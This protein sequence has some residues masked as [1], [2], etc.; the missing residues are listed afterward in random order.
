[1]FRTLLLV[2]LTLLPAARAATPNL[3][4][5]DTDFGT[6]DS[7]VRR[8]IV[9]Q[10]GDI[11]SC[12][13]IQ[14]TQRGQAGLRIRFLGAGPQQGTSARLTFVAKHPTGNRALT[15]SRGKCQPLKVNWNATVI[16]ASTAIFNDRGLPTTIPHSWRMQG[17]CSINKTAINCESEA[18]NGLL[19]RAQADL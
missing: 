10:G 11:R 15:C 19:L 12:S 14:L 17:I 6:F 4:Q 13:R 3:D 9:D 16:S 5:R 7:S 2:L 18:S 8:C 1:M